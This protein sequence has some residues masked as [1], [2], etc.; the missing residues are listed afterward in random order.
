MPVI[1]QFACCWIDHTEAVGAFVS[2]RAIFIHAR[3]HS[4]RTAQRNKDPFAVGRRVNPTRPF[5]HH[6]VGHNL[7]VVAV[8]HGDIPGAFVAHEYDVGRRFGPQ[9][10]S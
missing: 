5:A 7:I 2:G 8:N 4:R 9:Y 3:R 10:A 6:K 1:D